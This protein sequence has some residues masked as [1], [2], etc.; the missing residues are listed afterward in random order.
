MDYKRKFINTYPFKRRIR[1][2]GGRRRPEESHFK[3][4]DGGDDPPLPRSLKEE[5]FW[6][7][8][9]HLLTEEEGEEEEEVEEEV[10]E[11]AK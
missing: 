3:K 2:G 1:G 6:V 8:P 5:T 10:E 4:M 11:E 7:S 9:T